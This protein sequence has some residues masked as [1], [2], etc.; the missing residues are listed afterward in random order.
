[1]LLSEF[2]LHLY[3]LEQLLVF[4]TQL[5]LAVVGELL[6]EVGVAD[7]EGH[8]ELGAALL[9]QELEVGEAEELERGQLVKEGLADP[10]DLVDFCR[11][12]EI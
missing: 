10:K 6:E 3:Q 7:C 2:T 8:C 9:K 1:M 4:N 11:L 12:L 5:F